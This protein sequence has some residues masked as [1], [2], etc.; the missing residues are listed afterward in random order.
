MH[1]EKYKNFTEKYKRERLKSAKWLYSY[2][3]QKITE[4]SK[5]DTEKYKK[6]PEKYKR[7]RL[8]LVH[9]EGVS[10]LPGGSTAAGSTCSNLPLSFE[11]DVKNNGKMII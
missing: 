4:K 1:T 5:K 10:S 7:E 11:K 8:R 9:C 3:S 6:F 2:E